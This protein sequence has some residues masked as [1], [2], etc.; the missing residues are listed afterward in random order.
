MIEF[1]LK[2]PEFPIKLFDSHPK[3][4]YSENRL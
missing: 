4:C 3:L 1:S 2:F